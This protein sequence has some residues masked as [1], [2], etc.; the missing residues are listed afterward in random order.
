MDGPR[1]HLVGIAGD[2][3]APLASLLL[4]LGAEVS[5]SDLRGGKVLGT[6]M[7]LGANIS[8]GHRPENVE[9]ADAV[10]RSSAV[11]PDNPEL[12]RARR[13]GIPIH[14]RLHALEILLS[15]RRLIAVCGTHGKTT[16]TAWISY[17]LRRVGLQ[18]G[19]YIGAEVRGLPRAA[20][21]GESWFVAEVDESDGLFLGLRPEIA[22]LTNVDR[23]HLGTYGGLGP[24]A[25]AFGRFLH[26]ARLAVF[27]G[28]DPVA[29]EVSKG[30]P[31]IS[32]GLGPGCVVRARNLRPSPQGV[33]F[34]VLVEGKAA[35]EARIPLLGRHNVLNALAA[36]TAAWVMGTSIRDA[37]GLLPELPLPARRLELIHE[38]GLALVDDYAHHPRE[39]AAGLEALRSHWPERR[40]IALFQPHRYSRTATLHRELGAALA[41]ADLAVVT[42][43]YPAFEDPIPG[44]SGRLVVD[45][46]RAHGGRAIF[47]P[48]PRDA[49]ERALSAAREGDVVVCFGAG[50]IWVPFRRM[51]AML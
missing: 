40:I 32:Y 41:G 6:L 20:W 3:M 8:V 21:G 4:E 10:I 28:D 51:A 7:D 16:T 35:G 18:V 45:R 33:S 5:G 26:R 27:C 39:I 9:G 14:P 11:P 46:A 15:R 42:D 37:L 43:V 2:G 22:V 34:E 24:L 25:D 19:F 47:V 44:V 30:G 38:D 1:F 29:R 31:S 23:D 36:L 17:I 48:D 50:D 49:A 13:A 12:A